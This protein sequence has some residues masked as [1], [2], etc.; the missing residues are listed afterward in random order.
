MENAKEK[1]IW[2]TLRIFMGWIML[3]PFLDKLFGLGFSTCF[4]AKAGKFLGALCDKGTWL[5]GGSPT[6]GFLKLATKGPFAGI[7]QSMAGSPAVDWLF[8]MGLLLIGLCMIFGIGVRIAGYSGALMMALMY[9]ASAIP[10][11]KN[12][13]IDDH[14]VYAVIFIGLAV[15]RAGRYYG[16]GVWWTNTMLVKKFPILE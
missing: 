11:E 15:V 2:L 12:P 8:M 13:L 16:L 14:V 1:I 3:W 7:F 5:T 9:L 10:P 6:F 4:D